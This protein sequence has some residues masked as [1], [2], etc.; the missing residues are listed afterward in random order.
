MKCSTPI[1]VV[2]CGMP[3]SG[4][5]T[6]AFEFAAEYDANIHSSDAIRAELL[7]DINN[8]NNNNL[9]FQT[10]H[11]RIK[12]DLRNGKSCIYDACNVHYKERIA[13][14]REIK[15][16]SCKKICVMMA[17]PYEV[18][19]ERS[20]NRDRH[21]PEYV[22]KRMYNNFNIP[23]WYEGW[24]DIKICYSEGSENSNNTLND[25]IE[26]NYS[27]P[28]WTY[29][30]HNSHHEF[31][32]GRHMYE[33]AQWMDFYG[34]NANTMTAAALHDMSKPRVATFY[35]KKGEKTEDCHYYE[36]NNVS[37]YDSLFVTPVYDSDKLTVATIIMW[38]MQPYF[39]KTQ[40]TTDK[41]RKLW[42]EKLYSDIMLLHQCDKAAHK[43]KEK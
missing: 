3:C 15:D 6:K 35:N 5:S 28:L 38:H 42:G 29:D 21:V 40:K 8:Q 10:L 22:I 7:G 1:V 26:Q 14:L 11:K 31:T 24:D 41:Y 2:M 27:N 23:Y 13:F 32:L 34:G 30:Q 39:N 18:C 12:D 9:V 19:I 25:I 4:K 37:A 20:N 16:I 33:T 17:T 36:H 43:S